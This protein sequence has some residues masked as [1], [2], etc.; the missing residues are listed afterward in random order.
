MEFGVSSTFVQGTILPALGAIFD[1]GG[2]LSRD[3]KSGWNRIQQEKERAQ[4]PC[5]GYCPCCCDKIPDRRELSMGRVYFSL[6]S[7]TA[8]KA[9]QRECKLNSC[10]S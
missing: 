4:R 10:S 3:P 2:P 7:I 9:Q 8:E 1:R 5:I 6:W